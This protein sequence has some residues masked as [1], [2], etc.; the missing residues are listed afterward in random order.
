MQVPCALSAAHAKLSDYPVNKAMT[1]L[2]SKPSA[3]NRFT[4]KYYDC[5]LPVQ[6]SLFE[7]FYGLFE[8]QAKV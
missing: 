8:K 5:Y 6:K 7:E 4:V 3:N 2:K 1:E